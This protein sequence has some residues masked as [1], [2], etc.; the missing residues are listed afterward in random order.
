MPLKSQGKVV[1]RIIMSQCDDCKANKVCDHNRFGF[2]NCG[3]FI[4]ADAVEIV[5]DLAEEAV[6]K[7]IQNH[8]E[9]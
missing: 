4:P 7:D 9:K 1:R 8:L 3:N 5:R 2:E 6:N